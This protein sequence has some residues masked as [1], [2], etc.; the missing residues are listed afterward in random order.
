MEQLRQAIHGCGSIPYQQRSL[1]PKLISLE[2]G[3][4]VR[5]RSISKSIA[6]AQE[7]FRDIGNKV[8]GG[9]VVLELDLEKAYDRVDWSF[10]TG[11][12]RKFG[13]SEQWIQLVDKCWSN[14]WFSV[15]INGESCGFFKSSPGLRQGDPISPNLFILLTEALSRSFRRLTE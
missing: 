4:F 10:L 5:G 13:F 14:C 2:Q 3:A 8:K 9:N 12:L 7:V 15:L 11:V 1:L 6:L